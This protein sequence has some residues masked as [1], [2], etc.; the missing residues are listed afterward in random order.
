MKPTVP[1]RRRFGHTLTD[2]TINLNI[3]NMRTNFAA[4]LTVAA[5]A[6]LF[7]SCAKNKT[8]PPAKKVTGIALDKTSATVAVGGTLQ[9]GVTAIMPDDAADKSV[10]W[11]S[12]PTS[13][14]TVDASTGLVSVPAGVAD[15][16]TATVTATAGDGSGMTASCAITVSGVLINGVVW[17]TCNADAFDTFAAAPESY[18]MFYRWNLDNAWANTGTATGWTVATPAG[19]SWAE[20]NDPCPA[21]W[22]VPTKEE[23]AALLDNDA[24][25]NEWV[26]SYKESGIAGRQ[27][28]DKTSDASVFFP[29]AGYRDSS[30]GALDATNTEGYYWSGSFAYSKI[31]FAFF[32]EPDASL[33][34]TIFMSGLSVRC[35]LK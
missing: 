6:L 34:E 28:T 29:S 12:D 26:Y 27:F 17:A 13:V 4:F 21:G 2:Q 23:Y 11:S 35:V 25:T 33:G 5:L 9:L 19:D 7:A 1:A 31:W 16:A 22:C 32:H 14:A 3:M 15:G 8:P 24:V 30:T 10:T 20:E 18:G